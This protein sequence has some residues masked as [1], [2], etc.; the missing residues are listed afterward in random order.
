MP[1][2]QGLQEVQGERG[3]RICELHGS[4]GGCKGSAGNEWQIH[5]ESAMPAQ[6]VHALRAQ[7]TSRQQEAG[8]D[9]GEPFRTDYD[10][11]DAMTLNSGCFG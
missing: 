10:K 1:D 2:N 6:E 7:R 8:S 3:L 5:R 11:A 9:D 4:C